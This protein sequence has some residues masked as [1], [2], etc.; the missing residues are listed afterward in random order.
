MTA[1]VTKYVAR[2]LVERERAIEGDSNLIAQEALM[3]AATR[4]RAL[5][6]PAAAAFA[7][8]LCVGIVGLILA[9]LLFAPD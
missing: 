8:G 7:A 5:W 1:A 9:A 4:R 6:L 2:R 3:D